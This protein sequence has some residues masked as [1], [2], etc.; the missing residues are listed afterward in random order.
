MRS[1]VLRYAP[2]WRR[3]IDP[4][5]LVQRERALARAEDEA[6]IDHLSKAGRMLP[7]MRG[8]A[9]AFCDALNDDQ[10]IEFAEDGEARTVGMKAAFKDFLKGMPKL[11]EFAEVA[12]GDGPTRD[13]D[14][15]IDLPPGVSAS[16]EHAALHAKAKAHQRKHGGSYRDAVIATMKST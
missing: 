2:E 10:V 8:P 11:V 3:T 12:G 14:G 13:A 1:D 6:F 4:R 5:N 15:D 9:L 7:W 16:P